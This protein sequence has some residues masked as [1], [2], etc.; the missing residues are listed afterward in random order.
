MRDTGIEKEL[1]NAARDVR[2]RISIIIGQHREIE[3]RDIVT[4]LL[5]T[6]PDLVNRACQGAQPR[7]S[8][9]ADVALWLEA[10][11]AKSASRRG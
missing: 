6:H 10:E 9:P 11:L 4:D 7:F 5:K 1:L 3:P 8:S 2:L